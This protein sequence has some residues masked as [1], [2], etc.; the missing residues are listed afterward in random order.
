MCS[1]SA[2]TSWQS[3][4]LM[5]AARPSPRRV[6][7]IPHSTYPP[8]AAAAIDRSIAGRVAEQRP[9]MH[10]PRRVGERD[11]RRRLRRGFGQVLAPRPRPVTVHHRDGVVVHPRPQQLLHRLKHRRAGTAAA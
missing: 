9:D 5:S 7:L 10:R 11:E 6:V 2:S 1:V 8:S 3:D 4:R